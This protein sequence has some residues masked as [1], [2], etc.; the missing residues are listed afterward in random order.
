MISNFGHAKLNIKKAKAGTKINCRLKFTVGKHGINKGGALKI[1]FKAISDAGIPQFDTPKKPNY[2]TIVSNNP[3]VTFTPENSTTGLHHKL[4]ERPW[5]NGFI[6]S[7]EHNSLNPGETIVVVFQNWQTQTF[8]EDKFLI[9]IFIDSFGLGKFDELIDSPTIQIYPSKPTSLSVIAPTSPIEGKSFPIV[10][11]L[12]DKWGNLCS[13]HRGLVSI[14]TSNS[15]R[16][17]RQINLYNGWIH[18][19]CKSIG[20]THFNILATWQNKDWQSNPIIPVKSKNLRHFWADLH[21]QS[22]VINGLEVLQH[23][24]DYARD[25]GFLDVTCHQGND[26]QITNSFWSTLRAI[27]KKQTI[28]NKHI[29]FLGYEWSGNTPVGGDH[30][31]V[32]RTDQKTISRSSHGLLSDTKDMSNDTASISDLFSTLDASKTLMIA[33]AGG[34][35]ANLNFIDP[36]F[37]KLV[38]VHSCWGTNESLVHS[39]LERHMKVGIVAN[40]DGHT[41]RPGGETPGNSRMFKSNGGLTCVLTDKLTKNSI[42][43]AL[44]NRHCYGTTGARIFLEISI[45]DSSGTSW[46][47]GDEISNVINGPL[48]MSINAIGTDDLIRVELFNKSKIINSWNPSDNQKTPKFTK[49]IILPD[50]LDK[51]AVYIKISQANNECAWSS[52]IFITQ[53]IS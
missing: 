21:W 46:I 5:W 39:A 27:C 38:E 4:H 36:R 29:A 16:A 37:V 30:N 15:K 10:L 47:M 2:V 41:N 22:E 14:S 50:L 25:I 17:P 6:L 35:I 48:I 7:I 34:R 20:S 42:F 40:S 49:R 44:K 23:S 32:F 11:K 45:T 24:F 13:N 3:K 33:H 12:L 31:V 9:K 26:F 51:D 52:P 28:A 43:S 8:K 19:N 1:L 53:H 18:I